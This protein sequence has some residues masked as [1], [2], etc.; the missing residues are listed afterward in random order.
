MGVAVGRGGNELFDCVNQS[1]C[2]AVLTIPLASLTVHGP[3]VIAVIVHC[4]L[5]VEE[6]SVLTGLQR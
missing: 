5:A 4:T 6:E 2:F 3:V 1:G